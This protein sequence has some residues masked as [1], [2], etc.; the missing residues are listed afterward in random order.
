MVSAVTA[1]T[2]LKVLRTQQSEKSLVAKTSFQ[3]FTITNPIEVFSYIS[4]F[5]EIFA[6]LCRNPKLT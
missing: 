6:F 4:T 3:I 2:Y 1:Y 5:L